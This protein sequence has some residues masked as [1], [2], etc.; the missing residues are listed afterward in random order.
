MLPKDCDY[1]MKGTLD[2]VKTALAM[3]KETDREKKLRKD[4]VDVAIRHGMPG[5]GQF[6]DWLSDES[7][8]RLRMLT[9]ETMSYLNYL[10]RFASPEKETDKGGTTDAADR[11]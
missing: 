10:R 9:S 11:P 2:E 7:A 4:A 5:L 8:A 3:P 1:G 6:I